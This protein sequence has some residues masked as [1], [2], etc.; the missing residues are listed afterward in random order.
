MNSGT[1]LVRNSAWSRALLLAWET[2]PAALA[3]GSDQAVFQRLWRDNSLGLW[4]HT[5]RRLD[6]FVQL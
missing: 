6:L 2:H 5:V 1:L 3:G 4:N